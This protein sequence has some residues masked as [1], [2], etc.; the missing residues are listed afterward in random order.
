[1]LHALKKYIPE[2]LL[3]AYHYT[4]ARLAELI[5]RFPSND[6]IVIGVTGTN[7]KSS[8]VN[9]IAQLLT[10][11]GERVGYTSTAGFAI[12]G[13]EIE[14]RLKMT[15][16]GRLLLQRL[17]R[18]MLTE[19]CRYAVIETS[20]QGLTQFRHLG[21]NYDVALFTNL[22]PEHIEAHGGFENYKQAKAILFAHLTKRPH[23]KIDDREVS[24][25]NIVNADDEHAGYYASF[26]ADRH[27]R[28]GFSGTPSADHLVALILEHTDRGT[29]IAVNGEHCVLPFFAHFEVLNSL[30]AI[31]A[32]TSLG[33]AL[34]DVLRAAQE[35]HQLPGRFQAINAGQPF[36]VIVDYAYEPY[37]LAAL[38]NS[39]AQLGA[40][41]IIG[42][43]GSAGGGRDV[44]RRPKIGAI[45]AE[46]EDVVIVTN[47]DPYDEDPR[48]I[49]EAV[50]EGARAAGKI[51]GQNLFLIDDRQAAIEFALKLAQAG[52]VVLLT[53]KG[54]EPVMAVADGKKVAWDDRL[55]ARHALKKMGYTL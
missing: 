35:L 30:A 26:A 1:M 46:H 54:S 45:A 25:I 27:V 48:F 11:L 18:R 15:M 32:V 47:E 9:F 31:T 12:A 51:D 24:K 2:P 7:G 8:T 49:I 5:Y 28:Y 22:T 17:L 40:K 14:N 3:S 55:A 19:R 38:Y 16:P 43:H 23:K 41:R 42:V 20:S 39:V 10:T 33:F 36:R 37:A 6:L 29:V 21:I 13:Q 4:L 44:A 50:A 53:G 34:K 52:D